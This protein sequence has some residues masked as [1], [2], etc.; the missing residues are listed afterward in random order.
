[1]LTVDVMMAIGNNFFYT[2][3]LPCTLWFF[4]R[5]KEL[6]NPSPSSK[7]EE[8]EHIVTVEKQLPKQLLANARE[9]RKKQTA[10]E[11]LL[12]QLLRNRQ[13]ND[14]KFRRQHP[15]KVGFIL[16]FYC[17]EAK[18]GI[19]ID[20]AYHNQKEQQLRDVERTKVINEYGIRIIRFTNDQVLQNIV[21]VLNDIIEAA[22]PPSPN[23]EGTG[24]RNKNSVLMLDARKIYR[25]VTSKV[26]DFSPEQLQ[27]LICI[28]NLYRGNNKKFEATVNGY[29]ETSADLAKETADATAE[30]QKQLKKIFKIF[31]E[32]ATQYAKENKEAK[33]FVD[34]LIIEETT[35]IY[36]LQNKLIAEAKK[37]KPNIEVLEGISHLC[38]ALRKPQDKLIKQLL[39]VISTAVKEYQLNK[40]KAWKELN[41]QAQFIAPLKALQQQLSGNPDEEEPGLLHETEY[42]YKQAHWLTSRFP[43]GVYTDVE[44]LCKVVTQ[45]EIEAKDWSL[46]PGRYV[47]VDTSTD[48]D[49]D[50]EERLNEIHIELEGLNEEAIALAK[51]ISENYKELAI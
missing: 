45:K 6:L 50:Y 26:N 25:K 12:W 1:M 5:G 31:S 28:V 32:F 43:D 29:L 21:Q 10:P 9:L 34:A 35:S 42:F 20:G 41:V 47:G 16:D 15:L 19:E 27:N 30:L 51:V 38:K 8:S 18:L 7:G 36:E 11:E 23:G 22:S 46:S 33:S 13:L 37:T 49:F 44:G 3:S 4:D 14:L 17:A 40:N 48:E 39:D 24:V 2:R